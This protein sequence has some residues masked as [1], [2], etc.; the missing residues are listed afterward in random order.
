MMKFLL[1]SL[2]AFYQVDSVHAEEKMDW[3]TWNHEQGQL[4]N[5]FN[6]LSSEIKQKPGDD[7]VQNLIG[8]AQEV[9]TNLKN[10]ILAFQEKINALETDCHDP[11]KRIPHP[12]SLLKFTKIS[13]VIKSDKQP[14]PKTLDLIAVSKTM[15]E[16]QNLFI[17]DQRDRIDDLS[18]GCAHISSLGAVAPAKKGTK[19]KKKGKAKPSTTP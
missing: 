15:Q 6:Q 7:K 4:E 5:Q 10:R 17:K 1:L 12:A 14:D 9:Q 3:N 8:A 16:K 19:A 2:V 18:A 13:N 11:K